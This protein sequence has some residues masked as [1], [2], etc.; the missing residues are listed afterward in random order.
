LSVGEGDKG[1]TDG[2]PTEEGGGCVAWGDVEPEFEEPGAATGGG[3]KG[4]MGDI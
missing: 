3:D 1:A 4:A 2:V